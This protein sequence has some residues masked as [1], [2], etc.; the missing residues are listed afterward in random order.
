M[1]PLP[2]CPLTRALIRAL[3]LMLWVV[4]LGGCASSVPK[5]IRQPPPG[6]LQLE[7]VLRQP[8]GGLG[9]RVR[10]G[11]HIVTVENAERETR[12]ILLAKPLDYGGRPKETDLSAGRFLARFDGFRDPV[13]YQEGRG[14]T[15]V[16][17]LEPAM[18][19]AVGDYPYRYPVVRVETAYLWP[20]LPDYPPAY[21]WYPYC[22]P[23]YDPFYDCYWDPWYRPGYRYWR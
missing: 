13:T 21:R 8:Q 23:F 20:P 1:R 17:V 6:D 16:G 4:A 7:Q 9:E 14:L 19:R 2:R 10:W 18:T 5:E 3:S 22:S 11:G 15:V 12:V